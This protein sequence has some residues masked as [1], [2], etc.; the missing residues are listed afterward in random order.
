MPS[1]ANVIVEYGPY[2]SNG[3]VEYKED[4]L[5]GLKSRNLVSLLIKRLYILILV[6][7]FKNILKNMDTK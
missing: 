5:I 2:R 4:R 1:K 3:I 6:V 7:K